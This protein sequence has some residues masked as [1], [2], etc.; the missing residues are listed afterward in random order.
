MATQL[1]GPVM[2]IKTVSFNSLKIPLA[3]T[4][5]SK[6]MLRW[7]T[8]RSLEMNVISLKWKISL[9]LIYN[10]AAANIELAGFAIHMIFFSFVLHLS[11]QMMINLRNLCIS[12]MKHL[13]HFSDDCFLK[14]SWKSK[15]VFPKYWCHKIRLLFASVNVKLAGF[16]LWQ[17]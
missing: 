5:I 11:S 14:L 13:N 3:N 8:M 17:T 9:N 6:S 1:A 15:L 12:L 2:P 4:S 7:I 16:C 10:C